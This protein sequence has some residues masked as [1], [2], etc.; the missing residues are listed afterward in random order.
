MTDRRQRQKEQ[1]AARLEEER[2]AATRKEFRRRIFIALGSAWDSP[3]LCS[4]TSVIG[5]PARNPACVIPGF[6]EQPTACGAEAPPEES[7]QSFPEPEDQGLGIRPVTADHQHFMWAD[8]DWNWI[9]LLSGDGQLLRVPGKSRASTTELSSIGSPAISSSR[10]VIPERTG[11]AGPATSSPTSSPP[12]A[13]STR[14]GWSQWPMPEAGTT[15]SQFFIV[16]GEMPASQQH[17]QCPRPCG[18]R[19]GERSMPSSRCRPR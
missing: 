4:C 5:Q 6:R 18:F 17:I 19:P 2:K 11:P 16:V 1:R 14:R 15:G 3:A 9:R 7:V 12:K 13:S 10:E 8:R